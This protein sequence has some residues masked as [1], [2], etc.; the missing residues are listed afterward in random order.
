[1]AKTK[2]N[3]TLLDRCA[4]VMITTGSFEGAADGSGK[5]T[6]FNERSCRRRRV[7]WISTGPF[8]RKL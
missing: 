7:V 2:R 5:R 4:W 1:M 6:Y 3:W 8:V